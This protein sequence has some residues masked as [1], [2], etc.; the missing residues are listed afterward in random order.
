LSCEMTI[1]SSLCPLPMDLIRTPLRRSA[2]LAYIRTGF[3]AVN[4]CVPV[5]RF[6][7]RAT[8]KPQCRAL[9]CQTSG[10]T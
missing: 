3:S 2:L 7:N 10:Y 5:S 6:A 8:K 1:W 9:F 4:L